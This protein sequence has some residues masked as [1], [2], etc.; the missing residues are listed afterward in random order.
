MKGS[1]C[2]QQTNN[3]LPFQAVKPWLHSSLKMYNFVLLKL[4]FS[5][6][7]SFRTV[8]GKSNTLRGPNP[9]SKARLSFEAVAMLARDYI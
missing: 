6:F 7:E 1:I 3:P 5:Y 4:N 8:S 9:G 2:D